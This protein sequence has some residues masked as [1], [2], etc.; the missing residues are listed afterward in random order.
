MFTLQL[1]DREKNHLCLAAYLLTIVMRVAIYVSL[2]RESQSLRFFLGTSPRGFGPF[3]RRMK[4]L[5]LRIER[6]HNI[7]LALVFT[8]GALCSLL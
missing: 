2:V 8:L 1:A 3:T 5:A 6:R 4:P 7:Y